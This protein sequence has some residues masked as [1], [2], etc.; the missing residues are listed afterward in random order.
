[1]EYVS[2]STRNLNAAVCEDGME[3]VGLWTWRF[4][5]EDGMRVEM[6]TLLE[7]HPVVLQCVVRCYFI[8]TH[9]MNIYMNNS[10]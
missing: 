2:L 6:P 3:Y 7:V 8:G 5:S 9:N 10:T 1:M 4:D